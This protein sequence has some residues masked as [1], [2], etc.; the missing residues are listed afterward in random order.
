MNVSK[1][2][3]PVSDSPGSI[4]KPLFPQTSLRPYTHKVNPSLYQIN[5]KVLLSELSAPAVLDD[6]PESFLD[7]V[8]ALRFDWVW[9]LGVWALGDAGRGISRSN[10]EWHEEYRRALPD[11]TEKDICGSP[12]AVAG[13][14]V[15]PEL[16]G[17]EALARLRERLANRGIRLLLDFVPNHVALDHPW[18]NTHP[19]FFIR[20]TEADLYG[21]PRNYVRLPNGEIFAHGRDPYFPG[22]P[23]TLQL[24]YFNPALREQ[25]IA[26]LKRVASQCDGVRCDMAMLLEPEVFARTWSARNGSFEERLPHFW[27]EAIRRVKAEHPDFLFMAEVYWDY[28]YKL[29][30]HG[31]DYTYDKALYDRLV[32]SNPQAVRA[33][34]SAP[35]S[36]QQKMV[37]FLENHDEP[38]IAS[39]VSTDQSKAMAL[40]SYLTP[41]LR[42]FHRGQL[43]GHKIRVPVHLKRGPRETNNPELAAFYNT[44]L[45]IVQSDVAREGEWT[46]LTPLPAWKGNPSHDNFVTFLLTLGKDW[47]LVAVNLAPYRSQCRISLPSGLFTGANVRLVDLLTQA[48][49]ERSVQ[50]ITGPGLFIECNGY[51]GH[52]FTF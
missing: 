2:P 48:N 16:G 49:Y 12:F 11:L 17:D 7:E 41:G 45:P 25:M 6:L 15:A 32:E 5:T 29:Q 13:Y 1:V 26:E 44:L 9:P 39:R 8:K 51:K 34:L 28:E 33:H 50:E 40:V 4:H 47:L 30:Q 10:R 18:V 52:V 46:L 43:E 14:H 27:P 38:R 31:F 42:F 22:W 3:I 24:N 19:D 37:R 20:G 35:L 36:Y 23:D 21:Q